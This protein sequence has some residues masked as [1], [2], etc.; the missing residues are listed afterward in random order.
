MSIFALAEKQFVASAVNLLAVAATNHVVDQAH[1]IFARL[2]MIK[3]EMAAPVI[4]ERCH[5]DLHVRNDARMDAHAKAQEKQM[6]LLEH[7]K[8]FQDF[9]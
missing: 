5:P 8:S 3:K 2:P 6:N 1:F 7:T 9:V 4:C